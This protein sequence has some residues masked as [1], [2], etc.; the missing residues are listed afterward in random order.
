MSY[1]ANYF[2]REVKLNMQRNP[3]MNL[4]CI[5]NILILLISL[6]VFLIL[7]WNLN[8]LLTTTVLEQ[9]EI[10]VRLDKQ[11]TPADITRIRNELKG[12]PNISS[13]SFVSKDHALSELQERLV[14]KVNLVSLKYNPLPNYFKIKVKDKDK[15]KDTALLIEKIQGTEKVNYGEGFTENI[16]KLDKA[17]KIAGSFIILLLVIVNV[18]VVSNTIRLT[19]FARSREIRIMQL[20]GAANWFIRWPFIIE[21]ILQGFIGAII[22]IVIMSLTY[23]ELAHQFHQQLPFIPLI[24]SSIIIT[25]LSIVLTCVGIIVGAI[26]SFISVNK[27]LHL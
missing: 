22:A 12:L 9:L 20:V 24:H 11:V 3:L 4:A 14:Q 15:I 21:G 6:G 5:S 8:S 25:Q 27:F 10:T 17:I 18:L 1:G 7:I 19:V 13:I 16:I 23:P 2:F 26:G